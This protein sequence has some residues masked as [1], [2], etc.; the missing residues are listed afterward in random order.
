MPL[1]FISG[2][3]FFTFIEYLMHRYV[4]H[5]PVTNPKREKFVYTIHSVHHDYPK[6]KSRLTMP[7]VLSLILAAIFFVIYAS[8]KGDY[9]FG[10]LS[11]FL[12]GNTT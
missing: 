7:P 10:F 9:V 5:L 12:V 2:F 8:V 4:F 3:L 1:L 11:G 6:D